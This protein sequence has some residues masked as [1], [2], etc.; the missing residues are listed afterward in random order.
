MTLTSK[1]FQRRKQN[2]TWIRRRLA[3]RDDETCEIEEEKA[4]D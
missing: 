3:Y 4:E 2:R 1:Q